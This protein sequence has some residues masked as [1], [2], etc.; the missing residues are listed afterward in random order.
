MAINGKSFKISY[1]FNIC[2]FLRLQR[3]IFSDKKWWFLCT[4]TAF[5]L[6]LFRWMPANKKLQIK[7]IE[8]WCNSRLLQCKWNGKLQCEIW[9]FW[10][11][12]FIQWQLLYII[13]RSI[14]KEQFD[15]TRYWI[16]FILSNFILHGNIC[17]FAVKYFDFDFWIAFSDS[18]VQ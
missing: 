8:H 15:E 9:L 7:G 4:H 3:K 16:Q 13:V 5:L 17:F 10:F 18:F 2:R 14:R 12:F 11:Y 6:Y 1:E